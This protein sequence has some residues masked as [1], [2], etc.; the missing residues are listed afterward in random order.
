MKNPQD[1]VDFVDN[2]HE[3]YLPHLSIDCA[4]FA[5]HE[6]L[7]KVLLVRYSGH[8]NW[9][10]PGGFIRRDEALTRAAYRILA[11][12]TNITELYLRQ[13]YT[14]GDSATRLNRIEIQNNHNKAYAKAHVALTEDHWLAKRTLSVGYYALVEY[15]HVRITPDYLVEEYRWCDVGAIPQLQYDHNEIA[16]KA[17]AVLRSQVYQQPIARQLLPARFTFPEIQALYE[18]LLGQ[19][20]DRR[21]FRKRLLSLGLLNQLAEQRKIGPHRSPY[22]YEFVV[23][24]AEKEVAPTRAAGPASPGAPPT[25]IPTSIP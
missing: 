16:A 22:L 17:L 10:L 6:Q 7:L 9:S 15:E 18:A 12:K 24:S 11:E 2:F 1:V 21:N 25:L 20:F 13:F 4:V 8:E 14:F 5:Y 3:H 23:A 19:S